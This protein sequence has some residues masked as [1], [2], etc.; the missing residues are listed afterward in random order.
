MANKKKYVTLYIDEELY[1]SINRKYPKQ[2]SSIIEKCLV[3][4][5]ESDISQEELNKSIKEKV[6]D[7]NKNGSREYL[8]Y[9]GELDNFKFHQKLFSE[10]GIKLLAH[11]YL[12]L[13]QSNKL[14][15]KIK[16]VINMK[17]NKIGGEWLESNNT[18]N[19]ES[20]KIILY[21]EDEEKEEEH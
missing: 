1:D 13:I 16:E 19:K 20:K 14:G 4:F 15:F 12:D 17:N 7:I 18:Y 10:K 8:F 6:E 5:N 21:E 3:E 9:M 11:D 2:I